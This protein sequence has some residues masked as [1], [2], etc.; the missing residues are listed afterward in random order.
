MA[1]LWAILIIVGCTIVPLAAGSLGI[2]PSITSDDTAGVRAL[3]AIADPLQIV[4]LLIVASR[5]RFNPIDVLALRFPPRAVK[6]F[7][8]SVA[9]LIGLILALAVVT[10]FIGEEMWGDPNQ[11]LNVKVM[12][13]AGL[14]QS[15]L[16]TGLIAPVKEEMMFRG[17]LLLSFFNKRLWFWGAAVISSAAFAFIHNVTSI[18]LLFHIPYFM[19]GLAFAWALRYSGSLWIPI[20]LHVLKNSVAVISLSLS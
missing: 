1:F 3:Q 19:L 6:F 16:F 4:C 5:M 2:V 9:V 13:Q 8:I 17:L 20:G 7:I 11:E 18:N 10:V 14:A 15:L 12:Q